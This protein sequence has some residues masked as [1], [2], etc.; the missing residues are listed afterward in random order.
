MIATSRNGIHDGKGV[1]TRSNLMSEERF[2]C[3]QAATQ[4]H[5]YIMWRNEVTMG[6]KS[7]QE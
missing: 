6:Y 1:L 7:H 3:Q 5:V 4:G 2:Q